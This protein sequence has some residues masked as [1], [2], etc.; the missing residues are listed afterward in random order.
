M[1]CL[2]AVLL[3]CSSVNGQSYIEI[4][5]GKSN[6]K[7]SNA[8]QCT[9][10]SETRVIGGQCANPGQ[11]PWV[12]MI[13]LTLFGMNIGFCGGAIIDQYTILTA[14]H[15]TKYCLIPGL[16]ISLPVQ[17]YNITIGERNLNDA[18]DGQLSY[19]STTAVVHPNYTACSSNN[20]NDIALL[21]IG[22]NGMKTPYFTDNG[23]GSSN[24]INLPSANNYTGSDVTIAG[25]GRTDKNSQKTAK[26]L[27]FATIQVV[28]DSACSQTFGSSYNSKTM[29]CAFAPGKSSCNGDSGTAMFY[30]RSGFAEAVGITSF[31]VAN[32]EGKPVVY[33]R[34]SNYLDFINSN[35]GP[36]KTGAN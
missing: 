24:C 32:C 1:I 5:C 7:P 19:T 12:T 2:F 9:P 27:Q 11:F 16:P 34:V 10:T 25:W 4:D 36:I 13:N 20:S 14:A 17:Q 22:G 21:K 35:I 3:L 23:L 31:G 30:D 8:T 33:T 18:N 6:E 15:C 28:D 29:I 26:I